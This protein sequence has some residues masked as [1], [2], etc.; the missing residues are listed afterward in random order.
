MWVT[1]PAPDNLLQMQTQTQACGGGGGGGVG[2]GRG[3][4]GGCGGGVGVAREVRG[5]A[6]PPLYHIAFASPFDQ[7]CRGDG[8][9]GRSGPADRSGGQIG[10]LCR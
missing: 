7:M 9:S 1:P 8:L 10:P 2:G 5:K 4:G 6:P 3:G